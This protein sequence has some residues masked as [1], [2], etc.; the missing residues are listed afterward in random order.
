MK[1]ATGQKSNP[2]VALL[3]SANIPPEVLW[4]DVEVG[5]AHRNIDTRMIGWNYYDW[6]DSV[7]TGGFVVRRKVSV[8]SEVDERRIYVDI[9]Y[10]GVSF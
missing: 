8:V 5:G 4:S 9:R 7:L 10:T 1:C 6:C 2:F 3:I